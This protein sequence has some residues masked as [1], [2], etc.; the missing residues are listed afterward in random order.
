VDCGNKISLPTALYGQGRCKKCSRTL[1]LRKTIS[2]AQ[3]GK[4]ES[5]E[6]CLKISKAMCGKNNPRYINGLSKNKYKSIFSDELKLKIRTRDNFTC[7]CCGMIEQTHIEKS[8]KVLTVHHVD[9]DK[10]NCKE[11][12][13]IAL[14]IGCNC[15]ANGTKEFDRDYYFAYYRYLIENR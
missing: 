8:Q 7:Q 1:E 4:K 13:L 12:N 3:T 2:K 11:D 6:T 9:Y 10:E 5:K 15:K 14:C